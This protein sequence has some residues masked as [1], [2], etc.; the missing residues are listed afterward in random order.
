MQ[1]SFAPVRSAQAL[2]AGLALALLC[3]TQA[4]TRATETVLHNFTNAYASG[5][6][7]VGQ[8]T[9]SNGVFYGVTGYGV[10]GDGDVFTMTATGAIKTIHE[11]AG[12]A[13]DGANPYSGLVAAAGNFYGTTVGGG[14]AGI[15]TIYKM[16]P[17]GAVKV[18]HSFTGTSKNDG[19]SPYAGLL[20]A[21]DGRLYGVTYGGGKQ[22]Q[23][24]VFGINT[25]GTGYAVIHQFNNT[26]DTVYNP[27]YGLVETAGGVLYGTGYSATGF[28]GGIFKL[29]KT[30]SNFKF[31]HGFA[32]TDLAG[33]SPA[34]DLIAASDGNLYGTCDSGGENGLGTVYKIVPGTPDQISV[35]WAF[36]GDTGAFPTSY[37]YSSGYQNRLLQGAD[38]NLYGVTTSGGAFGYGTMFQLSLAG[39]CTAFTDF[40]YSDCNGTANPPAQSGTSFYLTSYFGGVTSTTQNANG[41]G[42][43]VSVSSTGA[44]S[45]IQSFS[46]LDAYNSYAGLVQVGTG[47][48]ATYYGVTVNGGE[49]GQGAIF[50]ITAKGMFSI[51]HAFN[52]YAQEGAN[53]VGGLIVGA[54]K[55]LYGTTVNG[56]LFSYG[57]VF[58]IT[59]T[60]VLTVLHNFRAAEGYAPQSA[61]VQGT[62]KDTN[63]YGTCFYGGPGGV[64][65][66]FTLSPT[67]TGFRV[68]HYFVVNGNGTG[69]YPSGSLVY[70]GLGN[71]YGTTSGGGANNLGEIFKISTTGTG[72]QILFSFYYDSGLG[73]YPAGYGPQ[74]CRMM[75]TGGVLYGAAE[76]GGANSSGAI[77]QCNVSTGATTA[78]YSFNNNSGDG[79]NPTG[80]LT[81]ISSTGYLYGTCEAGGSSGAGTLYKVKLSTGAFTLLHTFTGYNSTTPA[82]SDG[83][84]PYGGVLLGA[85]GRLYGT[86]YN[87]GS[88]QA[89]MIFAQTP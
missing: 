54:D 38:G 76:N 31:V 50:S 43:A 64:G 65:S 26:L 47:T 78:L 51:V 75:L 89:G 58:R 24:T 45:L 77:F 86:T 60:G 37:S 23:G 80:N 21:S 1:L 16:T 85:D 63:L 3:A 87:G 35:L 20:L 8:L 53:P 71:L 18:I 22:N 44:L 36:D 7:P 28:S 56:G 33:Y 49:Y 81:Y 88:S 40:N 59:T 57:T 15:G 69:A 13:T 74:Y 41:Y 34:S 79:Y 12:G 5:A 84:D 10:N 67:G 46:V 27:Q 66:I 61:L 30:G 19:S 82:N 25:D 4:P 6:Y 39:A 70:D 73:T 52:N 9:L 55:A 72:L 29:T 14:S 32:S 2:I 17:A 62:G 48:T 11:F 42:A 83:A 68:L